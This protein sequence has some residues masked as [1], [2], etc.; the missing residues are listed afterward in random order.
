MDNNA[1]ER[2][3]RGPAVGRKNYYGSGSLWSGRLAAMMFS[4]LA[5]LNLHGLNERKWLTWFL[6]S[7]AA[8]GSRSPTD[9]QPFLP[10]NLTSAQRANLALD[11]N[12]TS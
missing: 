8:S 4:L 10:W 1:A 7:C 6:D 2:V 11:A 9:I 5:T 3:Q 12:N